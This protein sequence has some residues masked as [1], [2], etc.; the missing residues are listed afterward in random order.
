MTE[1]LLSS[2]DGLDEVLVHLKDNT[3]A[4]DFINELKKLITTKKENKVLISCRTHYFE[5]FASP[6]FT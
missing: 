2:L 3:K 4:K 6:I 1:M 5:T